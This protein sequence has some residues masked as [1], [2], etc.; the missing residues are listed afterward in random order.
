MPAEFHAEPEMGF[1][2]GESGLDLVIKI[3]VDAADYLSE[4]GIL[5]IEVGSSAET[6]QEKFPDIPFYWLNFENG[7]DGVF[8]LTAEQVFVFNEQFKA[9][10]R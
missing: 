6:L 5:V 2:G 8:L 4:Q 10:L 1:T 7:G 9:V 3:L